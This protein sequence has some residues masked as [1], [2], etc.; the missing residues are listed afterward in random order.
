MPVDFNPPNR[1]A[2]SAVAILPASPYCLAACFMHVVNPEPLHTS[3]RHE[4][5]DL[6]LLQAK[7]Q[8][9]QH[10]DEDL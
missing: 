2:L 10:L 1:L 7:A 6:Q 8:V 3:G 5:E 4:L 9:A